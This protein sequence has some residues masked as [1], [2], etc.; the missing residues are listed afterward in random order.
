MSLSSSCCYKSELNSISREG[1]NNSCSRLTTQSVFQVSSR[2]S[3]RQYRLGAVDCFACMS[4][5]LNHTP[6]SSPTL[7]PRGVARCLLKGASERSRLLHLQCGAPSWRTSFGSY[8][9]RK[10]VVCTHMNTL[11]GCPCFSWQA[12]LETIAFGILV[13]RMDFV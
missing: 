1:Y 8:L 4:R 2:D 3:S 12:K 6:L 10:I 9:C 11:E 13:M 5:L 7:I